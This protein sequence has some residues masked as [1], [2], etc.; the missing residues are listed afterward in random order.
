MTESMNGS[1]S[2]S[3]WFFRGFL[4]RCF[5]TTSFV[6]GLMNL[7]VAS[8]TCG[9]TLVGL[10]KVDVTPQGPI[11]LINVK[12]PLESTTV[13]HKLHARAM[14][15]GEDSEIVVLLNFDGIGVPQTLADKVAARLREGREIPRER[16]AIC[17]THTHWAPHLTDLLSN[18]YGGPL[19]PAHQKRID[20]YTATLADKLVLI[21]EQA[22]D[23]RR[24]SHVTWATGRASFAANRRLE[25]GGQLLR[26]EGKRLMVTWNPLAPVDHDLPVMAVHDARTGQLRG[27][28]FTYACHNVALTSSAISGFVNSI[29][30]DWVGLV[31]D[32]LESKYSDCVAICTIGCGGDQR[33]N[34]CGG[35]DVAAAHAHEISNEIERLLKRRA[36]WKAVSGSVS[37]KM[38]RTQLPLEPLPTV[39]ELES[40]AA[41]EQVS[42]AVVARAVVARHRLMELEQGEAPRGVPF[43]A[44]SWRFEQGPTMVFL[45]GEVCIDYQLRLKQELGPS[46]WPIAYANATPCY[47]VSRR[48]LK[49]GGYEAGNSMFYYGYLRSLKPECEEAVMKTV[50]ASIQR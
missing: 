25:A 28:H 34:V 40:M 47:I 41:A 27:L 46:M 23:E 21:A 18:I 1:G 6:F 33:P 13:A 14:A 43:S 30:G 49:K 3:P 36:D 38:I 35:I 8:S 32:E 26:D 10:A 44:Q 19:P 48:M 45:S 50:A 31:Q 9:A 12:E 24:P 17:A 20:E 4:R 7:L 2:M 11:H 15:I 39:E 42:P 37:A 22:I 29:H 16:I 5:R